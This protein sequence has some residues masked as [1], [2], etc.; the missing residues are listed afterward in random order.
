M[1]FENRTKR[2]LAAGEL[3]IGLGV[4][5]LRTAATPIL[6]KTAGYDWLFI[7]GEH[8]SFSTQEIGQL[9]LASL[10]TGVTPIVQIGPDAFHDGTRALD[11]G[12]QGL[13]VPH[14][15]TAEKARA[16]VD[17]FRYPP[18]GRRSWGG[19]PALFGFA[20]PA[21]GEAQRL[22]DEEILL[23]VMLE[24]PES[25]ENAEA[26]ASTPGIDIL[27]LGVGDL[28]AEMGIP[29]ERDHPRIIEAAKRVSSACRRHGKAMGI[30]GA[31]TPALLEIFIGI[32]ARFALAG[33]DQG[34]LISAASAQ[35]K[36]IKTLLR[37][38]G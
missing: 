29:D 9:C 34:L 28:S 23:T 11:N 5:H 24:S 10:P 2:L 27:L 32:G 7:L 15:D 4:Y 35:A 14:V 8:G 18:I 26:I 38:E 36:A 1:L 19:P 6:A 30:G 16:I 33:S 3:A 25:I 22:S 37:S 20:P 17:A 13:I 31:Y 12:A 21:M